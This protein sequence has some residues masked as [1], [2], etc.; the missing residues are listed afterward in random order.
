MIS[1]SQVKNHDGGSNLLVLD[2]LLR[3]RNETSHSLLVSLFGER[4]GIGGGG[5]GVGGG[6]GLGGGGGG[7]RGAERGG[8]GHAEYA[9]EG[10]P[11]FEMEVRPG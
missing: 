6:G 8:G 10:A 2:T 7:V 4:S 3:V 9:D 1:L 5:G 11:R